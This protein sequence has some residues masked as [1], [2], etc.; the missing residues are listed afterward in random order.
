MLNNGLDPETGAKLTLEQAESG[1]WINHDNEYKT[2][3][4]SEIEKL[5]S[6]EAKNAER[7]INY[8]KEKHFE[9]KTVRRN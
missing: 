1:H 5:Y 6:E 7:A 4:E 2:T 3:P 9:N 8:L